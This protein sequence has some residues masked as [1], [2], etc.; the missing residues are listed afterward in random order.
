MTKIHSLIELLQQ[1][2]EVQG[3]ALFV[4]IRQI[5]KLVELENKYCVK[6]LWEEL[7]AEPSMFNAST[8]ISNILLAIRR[9]LVKERV[10]PNHKTTNDL[11]IKFFGDTRDNYSEELFERC[12]YEIAEEV[13]NAI[14]KHQALNDPEYLEM[15]NRG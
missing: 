5:D 9:S 4:T 14:A 1:Q 15:L 6:V 12:A 10:V 8:K 13:D 7:F 2:N 11:M 3:I